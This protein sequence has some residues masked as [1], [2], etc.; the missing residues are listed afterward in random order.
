MDPSPDAILASPPSPAKAPASSLVKSS[1]KKLPSIRDDVDPDDKY[2]PEKAHYLF[3]W[4]ILA[5]IVFYMESGALPALLYDITPLFKLSFGQKGVLGGVVY[6]AISFT[7]PLASFA[8]MRWNP[9]HVLVS[10]GF[11]NAVF[12]VLFA[13]TPEAP[14]YQWMLIATRAGIGATQCFLAVYLPVWIDA[15]GPKQNLTKWYA[16]LQASVPIGVMAGYLFG[17]GASWVKSQKAGQTHAC[18]LISCWR[19]PFIIQIMFQIPLCIASTFVA[20]RHLSRR[21]PEQ[22][23]RD[24]S[25]SEDDACAGVRGRRGSRAGEVYKTPARG[26]AED[27]GEDLDRYDGKGCCERLCLVGSEVWRV[28]GTPRFTLVILALSALF[29]VVTG[30]QY[31]RCCCFFGGGEKAEGGRRSGGRWAVGGGRCGCP[32]SSGGRWGTVCMYVCAPVCGSVW[33]H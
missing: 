23:L 10:M 11:V 31:V 18:G 27:D 4:I 19:I 1:S 17:A 20:S 8:F 5:Q 33:P 28:V 15:F 3:K 14:K 24:R 16:L 6:L 7:C 21:S 26:A 22:I 30:V 32:S 9:K 25:A 13:C 2:A 29:F 12:V